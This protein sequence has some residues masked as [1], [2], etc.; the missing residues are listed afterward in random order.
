MRKVRLHLR[1]IHPAVKV[2]EVPD[3]EHSKHRA[4]V[5]RFQCVVCQRGSPVLFLAVG[6]MGVFVL[7]L[8]STKRVHAVQYLFVGLAM[9]LM[10]YRNRH[11]IALDELSEMRG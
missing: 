6:F 11:S 7:E 8:L 4:V 10:I 2:G 1:R 9:V 5:S 3:R